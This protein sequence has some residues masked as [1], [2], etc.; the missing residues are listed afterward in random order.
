MKLLVA[1]ATSLISSVAPA[2][3]V[4]STSAGGGFA[5]VLRQQLT[6]GGEVTIVPT[7]FPESNFGNVSRDGR[8]ITFSSPD[9]TGTTSQLLPSSDL[10]RFDRATNLTTK[11]FDLQTQVD[12]QFNVIT[13]IPTFNA[14]SPDGRFVVASTLITGREGNANPQSSSNLDI[15]NVATG[16]GGTIERGSGDQFD[17]LRSE[18]V[19]I[20]WAPDS[21]SFVTSG[22]VTGFPSPN[23]L[24]I[25]I[26]RY[27]LGNNGLF[28]RSGVL[29]NPGT[30]Q[31]FQANIQIFPAVSPSGSGLA[32]FDVFI[33]DSALLRGEA[34]AR[35]IVANADGSGA[36]IRATLPQGRYPAG[37]SWSADGSQIVFSH[38]QQSGQN[39]TFSTS[40]D[41]GTQII[42]TV[43]SAGADTTLRQL[44]GI[45][46][47]LLPSF[48]VGGGITAPPVDLSSVPLNLSA[49]SSG[50]GFT[51]S[52]A[53]LDP[54]ANYILESTATLAG[55]FENP[56]TF[57]GAQIMGG[58]PI[59]QAGGR[60]FF[61]L[62][63]PN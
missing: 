56:V 54:A 57:T 6:P 2:Q 35:V 59:T 33:P 19:G 52:A 40:S 31:F 12:N 14:Q 45:E 24:N 7:G 27:T 44:P 43:A 37:L 9:P 10:Y 58:I 42:R 18:F 34:T 25:G 53:G 16:V 49:A 63:L 41:P 17:F 15:V 4:F 38:G 1:F 62:R 46:L 48:P 55:S 50:N 26:V 39:G 28:A 36:T 13:F 22:Y 3:L 60:A 8:F 47:G 32:Y 51:F 29:S 20:S 5:F 21:G 23:N 61:R 11:L 30:N